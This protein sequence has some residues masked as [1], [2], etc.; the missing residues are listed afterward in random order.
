MK[1][2]DIKRMA[3]AFQ[4]VTEMSSKEK[5]KKGL[6]NSK[7]DPVG[8]ED[9]DIDNDGDTDKSD[10]YLHNRRKTVKKAMSD[11]GNKK[12]MDES[13]DDHIEK[14]SDHGIQADHHRELAKDAARSGDHDAGAHHQMAADLHKTAAKKYEKAADSGNAMHAATA[15]AAGKKACLKIL[16]LTPALK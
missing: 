16:H 13:Y 2:E 6:Y 4:A 10:K 5:M 11:D 15:K 12:S 1:T 8:Q 7:M 14:A 9:D 3:L